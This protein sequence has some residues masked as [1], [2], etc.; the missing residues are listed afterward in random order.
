VQN[1]EITVE[2][3]GGAPLQLVWIEAGEFIMGA[4]PPKTK[5]WKRTT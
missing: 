3:P 1:K 4:A 2:L 5:S